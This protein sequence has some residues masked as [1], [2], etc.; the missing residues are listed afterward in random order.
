MKPKGLTMVTIFTAPKPFKGHFG[1]IQRNSLKS[2]TLLRPT[3]QIILFGKE[4]GS[5]EVAAELNL[6]HLPDVERNEFG[7]P[8]I[9][10]MFNIAERRA[11]HALLCYVNADIML[12]SDFIKALRIVTN[13]KGPFVMTGR[14]TLL[15]IDELW[16]FN[17]ADWEDALCRY[18][19]QSG[20]LDSWKAMDYFTF[21]RGTYPRIPPFTVGRIRWDNWMIYDARRRGYPVINATQNVRAIHQNH[22]YSH[23][24]GGKE[25]W[26]TGVEAQR[27][28]ELTGL[29]DLFSVADSTFVLRSGH[30]KR[31]LGP[32]YLWRRLYTL[33]VFHPVLAPLRWL[34]NIPLSVTKPLRRRLPW[35]H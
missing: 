16:D 8:L 2:W 21:P 9:S 15:D 35:W 29:R 11:S 10:S 28:Q 5:A 7:T 14:R 6:L 25:E 23:L 1:V 34:M 26:T 22:D 13:L 27:N 32:V 4:E 20:T 31:A 12:T 19:A 24:A 3:P 30:L 17:R 33:P 18:A